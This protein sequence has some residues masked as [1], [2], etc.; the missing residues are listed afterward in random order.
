MQSLYLPNDGYIIGS[1]SEELLD[2]LI[3]DSMGC[4]SNG[5][6]ETD[7]KSYDG[8]ET[9]PHYA[10]SKHNIEKLEKFLTPYIEEYSKNFPYISKLSFLSSNSPL[11][12][13][14]PWYNVQ[15]PNHFLPGHVH[16]GILSYSIWLKLPA[17]SEFVFTYS[18][19][20]GNLFDHHIS[21]SPADVGNF[22]LFPSNLNHAVHPYKSDNPQETRISL[23]GNIAFQGISELISQ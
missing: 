19:I 7:V 18:S 4:E 17:R 14:E 3:I 10:V 12:F 1:L 21:L 22:V 11:V 23:S 9:C 13:L 5:P 2:D 20:T 6:I 8:S 16:G 15:G